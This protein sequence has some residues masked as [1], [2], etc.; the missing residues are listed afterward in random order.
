MFVTAYNGKFC[1]TGEDYK[2]VKSIT[3]PEQVL[4]LRRIITGLRNGTILLNSTPQ[5]FDIPEHEI[6]Y[7]QGRTPEET[8]ALIHAAQVEDLVTQAEKSGTNITAAPGF[9][10]EDAHVFT[11]AIEKALSA[12]AIETGAIGKP[13]DVVAGAKQGGDNGD[14]GVPVGKSSSSGDGNAVSGA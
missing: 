13:G 6:D 12:S 5:H 9:Q 1:F 14:D 2:D 4:P 3:Q 8:N 7:R 11:D 10:P